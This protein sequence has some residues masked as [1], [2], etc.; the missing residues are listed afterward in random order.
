V[1]SDCCKEAICVTGRASPVTGPGGGTSATCEKSWKKTHS[2]RSH[3]IIQYTSQQQ[4]ILHQFLLEMIS[5]F[6]GNTVAQFA[7]LGL[8]HLS[9]GMS[10][11]V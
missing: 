6:C 8:Q 3:N 10:Y 1:T 9:L 4:T 7:T 2:N 11:F 5:L